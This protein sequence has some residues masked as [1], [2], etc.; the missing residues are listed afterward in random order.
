MSCSQ[1]RQSL[2]CENTLNI[3]KAA[4]RRHDRAYWAIVMPLRGMDCMALIPGVSLRSTPGYSH[5]ATNVAIF[6]RVSILAVDRN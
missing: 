3:L 1:G 4:K 2:G 5:G 6:D